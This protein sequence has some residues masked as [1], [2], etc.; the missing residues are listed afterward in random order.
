MHVS[1]DRRHDV[2]AEEFAAVPLLARD[3]GARE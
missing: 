2:R 1:D 3:D